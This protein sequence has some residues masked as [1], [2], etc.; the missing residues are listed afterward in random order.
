VTELLIKEQD[1]HE[2]EWIALIEFGV[3]P[4]MFGPSPAEAKPGMSIIA[5][6]VQLSKLFGRTEAPTM[7]DETGHCVRVVGWLYAITPV[8]AAILAPGICL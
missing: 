3:T 4:G 2:G 1:I 7:Q 8:T 6:G 5:N